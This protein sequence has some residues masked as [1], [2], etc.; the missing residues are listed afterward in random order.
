MPKAFD[1]QF[2]NDS[3]ALNM[4]IR[5]HEQKTQNELSAIRKDIKSNNNKKGQYESIQKESDS[6]GN[7][8]SQN[9]TKINSN[10]QNIDET[11]RII[12]ELN[13]RILAKEKSLSSKEKARQDEMK[14]SKPGLAELQASK[15][16]IDKLARDH[17][18]L[19]D[20]IEDGKKQLK[21]QEDKLSELNKSKE[22]CIADNVKL[23]KQ[24]NDAKK[25]LDDEKFKQEYQ[26]LS[27]ESKDLALKETALLQRINAPSPPNSDP[28]Q[29]PVGSQDIKSGNGSIDI[30]GK[31][32]ISPACPPINKFGFTE[33]GKQEN[34]VKH[35]CQDSEFIKNMDQ[36]N[37]EIV[38]NNNDDSKM[39]LVS[40][41]GEAADIHVHY[42]TVYTSAPVV[43]SQS[44]S[45]FSLM[46]DA[47]I[48]IL[49]KLEKDGGEK[50][51]NHLL[52][53]K[54]TDKIELKLANRLIQMNRQDDK[55]NGVP[56]KDIIKKHL[57][58]APGN[59][60]MPPSPKDEN[61]GD[62]HFEKR[63]NR[64]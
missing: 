13:V 46:V 1:K 58:D 4:Q 49:D 29:Q 2:Q 59:N 51:T 5:L 22:A 35:L 37:I 26:K 36:K 40:R 31:D 45:T 60:N 11:T 50:V 6:L 10:Q 63:F 21:Q 61:N 48:P 24:L 32:F 44:D 54:D 41:S 30:N 47:Y 57:P 16:V 55:I 42:S 56:L 25:K 39:K 9:I 34:S 12:T 64:L 18:K 14:K 3:Q 33:K 15:V 20:E 8:I 17:K 62:E 7:T 27:N 38:R 52:G 53:G 28:A 19:L 43:G 23:E